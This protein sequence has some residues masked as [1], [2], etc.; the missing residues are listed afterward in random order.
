MLCVYIKSAA[1]FFECRQVRDSPQPDGLDLLDKRFRQLCRGI[2]DPDGNLY[3]DGSC[4]EA[5]AFQRPQRGCKRLLAHALQ[6]FQQPGETKRTIVTKLRQD[7]EAPLV[8][9]SRQKR[10]QL[11]LLARR[12]FGTDVADVGFRSSTFSL[13]HVVTLRYLIA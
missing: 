2:V 1:V 7:P 3:Y 9:Q 5:I 11:M 12:H 10:A 6:T 4:N 8:Q 13:C